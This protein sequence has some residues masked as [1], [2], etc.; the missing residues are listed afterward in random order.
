MELRIKKTHPDAIIPTRAKP[1]DSGLDLYAFVKA[2]GEY[3]WLAP[4]TSWL[5]MLGIAIELPARLEGDIWR[6]GYEAQIRGRSSLT[7]RGIIACGGIG[8][9]DNG[10]RGEIGVSLLNLSNSEFKVRHGDRIAQLVVSPVVYPL[11]VVVDELG[12]TERGEAGFGST[13][14]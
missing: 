10:Y 13:G 9:V 7:R 8:T 12:Q 4:G 2:P 6:V 1:G 5:F 14:V 3:A 11:V